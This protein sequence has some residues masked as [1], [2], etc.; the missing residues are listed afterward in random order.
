MKSAAFLVLTVLVLLSVGR[1]ALGDGAAYL[2]VGGAMALM[3]ALIAV[4]FAWL[5]RS[6]ATPLALGMV[7]SWSGTAGTLLWWWSAAQWGAAGPIPD[8]PG[9]A[10]GVALHISGAVLH[11]LVIGRSLKLPQGLAIAIPL[12]SVALAGLVHTVI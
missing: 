9:L 3:A 2:L 10:F 7:L 12:L 11:F 5:W 6:N 8:H 1:A 4:T